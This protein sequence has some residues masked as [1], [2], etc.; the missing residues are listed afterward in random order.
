VFDLMP[1]R[2]F[3]ANEEALPMW[4][5]AHDIV[6]YLIIPTFLLAVLGLAR[7]AGIGL[8]RRLERMPS[9]PPVEPRDTAAADPF[10]VWRR[11]PARRCAPHESGS[12]AR[13]DADHSPIGDMPEVPNWRRHLTPEDFALPHGGAAGRGAGGGRAVPSVP[14]AARDGGIPVIR[15]RAR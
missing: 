13:S 3:A 4:A 11:S 1:P 8:L 12:G 5:Q 14:S 2:A 15:G 7:A 10:F 9:Q 6:R